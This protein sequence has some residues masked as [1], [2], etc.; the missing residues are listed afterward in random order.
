MFGLFRS[1]KGLD[2]VD[3][4]RLSDQPF[5]NDCENTFYQRSACDLC[6]TRQH[7]CQGPHETCNRCM[8][9]SSACTYTLSSGKG[10][11][12]KRLR[13]ISLA[14]PGLRATQSSYQSLQS[15][16]STSSQRS[17]VCQ[18][19]TISNSQD[20][21]NVNSAASSS[22]PDI[23]NMFGDT[24]WDF[25]TDDPFALGGLAPFQDTGNAA[26]SSTQNSQ[27]S[28]TG[29]LPL[30]LCPS[31]RPRPTLQHT[32]L[33]LATG[34]SGSSGSSAGAPP[35]P[36]LYT[37]LEL[38]EMIGARVGVLK[39]DKTEDLFTCLDRASNQ[40]CELVQCRLCR[41]LANNPVMVAT[42]GR[43]LV[44]VTEEIV[45]RLQTA[46]QG[47]NGAMVAGAPTPTPLPSASS[48][49][50]PAAS[51]CKSFQYGRYRVGKR[52]VEARLLQTLVRCH[53]DEVRE[54]L[55]EF[56]RYFM[57]A[58]SVVPISAAAK[59][60]DAQRLAEGLVMVVG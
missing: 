58:T 23:L 12:K 43:Q 5:A 4:V 15:S 29:P 35:C 60:E 41:V 26:D 19:N 31:P 27:R 13:K 14:H 32:G 8:A 53:V 36:C 40:C 21:N 34:S 11:G 59:L 16:A 49:A 2:E 48:A 17:P 44:A 9:T 28:S 24:T 38:L 55:S 25:A 56:S 1:D 57:Q 50:S 39:E 46:R 42:L 3:V 33:S 20:L 10:P 37:M 22:G 18:Q 30:H 51:G 6:R 7:K 54:L 45:S 52:Q 47:Y